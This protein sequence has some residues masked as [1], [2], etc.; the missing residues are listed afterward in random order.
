MDVI[1]EF[2]EFQ[3]VGLTEDLVKIKVLEALLNVLAKSFIR[4]SCKTVKGSTM[5]FH[6]FQDCSMLDLIEIVPSF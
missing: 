3:M 2:M 4:I 6:L 5:M 1:T